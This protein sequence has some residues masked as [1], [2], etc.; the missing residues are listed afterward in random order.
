MPAFLLGDEL[1]IS[2]NDIS[3]YAKPA[4]LQ[5]VIS[6]KPKQKPKN[7]SALTMHKRSVQEKKGLGSHSFMESKPVFSKGRKGTQS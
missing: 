2:E 1:I 7:V 4:K 3:K 5:V 6:E